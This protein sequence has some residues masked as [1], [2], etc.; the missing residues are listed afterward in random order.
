MNRKILISKKENGVWTYLLENEEIVEIHF[1]QNSETNRNVHQLGNIYIGRVKKILHN[2]GAAFIEIEPGVECYYDMLQV[3]AAIFVKKMGKKILCVGD[4]LLVQLSKE[5][6]KNKAPTVTS[7]L[8]FTG[9]YSVLTTGNTRMGISAKIPKVLRETFKEQLKAY[10]NEAYGFI[11][12]TNG[13][14]VDF[15]VIAE[16]IKTHIINY[17]SFIEKANT[18]TCFSCLKAAPE[19]YITDLKN[20]YAEGLTDII[21]DDPILYQEISS[22]CKNERPDF[23]EKIHLYNDSMLSLT[24]LY[25]IEQVLERAFRERVWLKNG[26]YLIIQPTEAL[27]VVDVNSGKYI[28]KGNNQESALQIN[29]EAAKEVAK[30]LRLRNLSGIIIVDF[31]N[32]EA[33]ADTALLIKCLKNCLAKDPI[34]TTYVDMTAL[35]LVEITRKK[36]RKPLRETVIGG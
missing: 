11:I 23:V 5:A 8:S 16:E 10:E 2:L 24:N 35:Q 30:Q 6:V 12:R 3:D 4:E 15:E 34:Q 27:T 14:E 29:L 25:N 9:Y 17:Q 32:M 7:N 21:I 20:S 33:A 19:R 1:D 18:R 28:K 22:F 31:I 26:A 36:I 13:K